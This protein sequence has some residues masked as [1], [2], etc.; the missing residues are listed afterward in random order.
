MGVSAATCL[1]VDGELGS[2]RTGR[3]RADIFWVAGDEI[4]TDGLSEDGSQRR[5]SPLVVDEKDDGARADDPSSNAS[6][7]SAKLDVER[8]QR[9]FFDWGRVLVRSQKA[10]R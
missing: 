3:W 9:P 6:R 5:W 7:A 8:V 10:T 4:S 2:A 1:D